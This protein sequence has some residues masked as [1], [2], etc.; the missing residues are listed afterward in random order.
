MNYPVKTKQTVGFLH[1]TYDIFMS[2]D[3]APYCGWD[4]EGRTIVIHDVDDFCSNVL[5]V[6][7]KH[8][9]IQSFVRQLNMYDF[10]KTSDN[11]HDQC[12]SHPNFRRGHPELLD[13]IKRKVNVKATK[14]A[15][16]Q[17]ELAAKAALYGS[18]DIGDNLNNSMGSNANSRGKRDQWQ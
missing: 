4:A 15:Q 12:F 8:R 2:P 18:G 13:L 11:P 10:H 5:P 16:A 7:F 6:Y 3:Y 1:K 17:A 14:Q 9:N